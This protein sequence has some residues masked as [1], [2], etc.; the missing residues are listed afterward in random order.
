[1]TDGPLVAGV[2]ERIE[3][4]AK[5]ATAAEDSGLHSADGNFKDLGDFFV[6]EALE[7]A[8]DHRAAKNLGNLSESAAND[9]LSFMSGELFEGSGFEIGQLGGRDGAFVIIVDGDLAAMVAEE[10]AALIESFANGDA[11]EPS[12]ERTT[13]AESADA[14]EGA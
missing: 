11:V 4:F 2:K 6:R 14:F 5:S 3:Q 10:P 12:F 8:E 13:A 9:G 7:I 1:M